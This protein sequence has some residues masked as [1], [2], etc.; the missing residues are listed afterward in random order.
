[1]NSIIEAKKYA[2]DW[3]AKFGTIAILDRDALENIII[4][5]IT[6]RLGARAKRNKLYE[7]KCFADM[8]GYGDYFADSDIELINN[9][10]DTVTNTMYYARQLID[11]LKKEEK[12]GRE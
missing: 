6:V 11:E 9:N 3:T 8:M 2:Q 4:K 10:I 12:E 1:M 5:H 7:I